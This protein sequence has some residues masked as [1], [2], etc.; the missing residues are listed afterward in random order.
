LNARKGPDVA[1]KS[2]RGANYPAAALDFLKFDFEGPAVV[3]NRARLTSL[4]YPWRTG[5]MFVLPV[6]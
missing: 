2:I 6:S 5:Q 1:E 3:E 4:R